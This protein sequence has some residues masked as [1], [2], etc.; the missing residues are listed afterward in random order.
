V[1]VDGVFL[2]SFSALDPWMPADTIG[3][4]SRLMSDRARAAGL[5]DLR[6]TTHFALVLAGSS[7]S[8]RNQAEIPFGLMFDITGVIADF[9]PPLLASWMFTCCRRG[10][11]R[12]LDSDETG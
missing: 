9:P 7:Q 3:Q 4:D 6:A 11:S 12:S 8:K 1:S 10:A 5:V 2:P